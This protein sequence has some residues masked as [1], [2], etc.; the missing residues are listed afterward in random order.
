MTTQINDYRFDAIVGENPPGA[1]LPDQVK[2]LDW[3]ARGAKYKATVRN[4]VLDDVRGRI[5]VLLGI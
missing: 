1:I 5:R 3:R 4:D 2:S